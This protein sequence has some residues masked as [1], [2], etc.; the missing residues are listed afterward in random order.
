MTKSNQIDEFQF[1]QNGRHLICHYNHAQIKSLTLSCTRKTFA[2][3]IKFGIGT[4][5]VI[6]TDL[7]KINFPFRCE[8]ETVHPQSVFSKAA[9]GSVYPP[10]QDNALQDFRNVFPRPLVYYSCAVFPALSALLFRVFYS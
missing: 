2:Y 10:L 3:T 4:V 1:H 9:T 7:L 6:N 8:N 5:T